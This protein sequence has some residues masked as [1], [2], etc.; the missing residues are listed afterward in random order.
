MFKRLMNIENLLF[1]HYPENELMQ[2]PAGKVLL[3]VDGE[4]AIV[5]IPQHYKHLP[6]TA[7]AEFIRP[8]ELE[9]IEES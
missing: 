3:L 8:S 7:R 5:D 6:M 9:S 2:M 1:K 4:G